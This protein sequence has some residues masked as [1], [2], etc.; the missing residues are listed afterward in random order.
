MIT[1]RYQHIRPWCF[2][3]VALPLWI[4]SI[5]W[6]KPL[7]GILFSVL[8]ALIV[9]SVFFK[10]TVAA[11]EAKQPGNA[12]PLKTDAEL[13]L[14]FPRGKLIA[15]MIV[16]VLIGAVWV[17]WS[18][19][20]GWF[21]QSSDFNARNAVFRDLI[22][23]DWPVIYGGEKGALVY[24]IGFW[25]PA[26][27]VGKLAALLTQDTAT[28]WSIANTAL[29]V[30]TLIGVFLTFLLI[31][32]QVR[33]NSLK[34]V[35]LALLVFLFF[36]G[37]DIIGFTIA[38]YPMSKLHLEWWTH[39]RFQYSSVTTTLFWVFN[40][41]VIT[42]VATLTM[43][44]E[45][46]PRYFVFLGVM[47]LFCGP[48]PFAGYVV[49]ALARG[50]QFW[51]QNRKLHKFYLTN[52]FSIPN[53]IGIFALFP[54][55]LSYFA[56][57]RAAAV[58]G[59]VQVTNSKF[60]LDATTIRYYTLFIVLEI[61]VYTLVLIYSNRKNLVFWVNTAFLLVCPF[62]HVGS[63]A[64]F[65]MR[66]SIPGLVYLCLCVIRYLFDHVDRLHKL[67]TLLGVGAICI[68]LTVGALTPGVELA[69]GVIRAD[70]K[71]QIIQVKDSY[72]T[73][74]NTSLSVK[75]VSNFVCP[76]YEET[77][78]FRVFAKGDYGQKSGASSDYDALQEPTMKDTLE[79]RK[80]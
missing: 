77:L 42:W 69:R 51:W 40:Q 46:K 15:L 49:L 18:G 22:N 25:L 30:W 29:Y 32:F 79:S 41:T 38:E 71:H 37:M 20:G 59:M 33:A 1:L 60:K 54:M 24:Y 76:Q 26:A 80:Q 7:W 44:Q 10:K 58:N 6:L 78:F 70:Q 35:A 48:L 73:L 36:S 3:Y 2:A 57:N 75:K 31:F 21:V 67:P 27:C 5:S 74:N 9:A 63:A 61:L 23:Y 45:N 13:A 39:T 8:I 66:A 62:I 28:V 72:K 4:F 55:V 56:C 12:R 68:V 16:T 11:A 17:W 65:C 52:L 53:L 64:D 14:T 34:K 50:I 43:L 47:C 19:I